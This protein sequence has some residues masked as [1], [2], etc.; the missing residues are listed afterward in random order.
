MSSGVQQQPNNTP[1]TNTSQIS[2]PH[3]FFHTKTQPTMAVLFTFGMEDPIP[4]ADAVELIDNYQRS[5]KDRQKADPDD[6]LSIFVDY[7][8]F[9]AYVASIA[10]IHASDILD[11]SG[12]RVYFGRTSDGD[13][14]LTTI[15][16]PTYYDGS[17]GVHK[18]ILVNPHTGDELQPYDKG[19]RYPPG[20]GG[21][22]K[23]GQTL[24]ERGTL[25]VHTP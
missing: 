14:R 17:T 24:A 18:D 9:L 15:Y 8:T 4:V 2:I 7:K 12:I 1:D 3:L 23:K 5:L 20:Q 11:V 13:N 6:T 10:E 19:N 16:T 21:N 25:A 22:E